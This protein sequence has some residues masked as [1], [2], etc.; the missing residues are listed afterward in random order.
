MR[1]Q[2]GYTV[3]EVLIAIAIMALVS[4][5]AMVSGTRLITTMRTSKTAASVSDSIA[6]ARSMAVARTAAWQVRF[7][8][9][10][11]T[12]GLFRSFQLESNSYEWVGCSG[13]PPCLGASWTIETSLMR[14]HQPWQTEPGTGLFIPG[15][16]GEVTLVFDRNGRRLGGVDTQMR[17]CTLLSQVDGT[18]AC[19]PDSEANYCIR[20]GSGIIRPMGSGA[21]CP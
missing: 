9:D 6:L 1:R 3:L 13:T 19:I 21:T 7:I 2:N 14:N 12:P 15:A 18:Q 11:T 10:G 8:P 17:V 20:S 16:T 4:S 5:M